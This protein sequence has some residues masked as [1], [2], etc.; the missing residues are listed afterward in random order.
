M[1]ANNLEEVV[2]I[3]EEGITMMRSST[4]FPDFLESYWAMEK[5]LDEK[6]YDKK[7]TL[8]R[9]IASK[10]RSDGELDELRSI[11]LALTGEKDKESDFRSIFELQQDTYKILPKVRRYIE[12]RINP[13][14]YKE[15]VEPDPTRETLKAMGFNLKNAEAMKIGRSDNT[16][17][18]IPRRKN[19]SAL[20]C[21]E[22]YQGIFVINGEINIGEVSEAMMGYD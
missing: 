16:K 13:T 12:K 9:Y 11:Q 22:R 14:H 20:R 17:I 1:T 5:N 6:K 10:K 7:E 4:T 15:V 18:E 3:I 21:L 19:E 2:R 8:E